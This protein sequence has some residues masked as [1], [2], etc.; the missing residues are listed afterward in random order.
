MNPF[1]YKPPAWVNTPVPH[2]PKSALGRA[3]D[4]ALSYYALGAQTGVHAM[5]EWCGVMGEH[6]KMLRYAYEVKGVE[7]DQVDQH[8][9]TKVEV[10]AFM[11][12]YFCE[13]LGCQLKPFIRGNREVWQREINKWFEGGTPDGG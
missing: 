10:P 11:V 13:K 3:D 2:E 9:G 6:V 5:I 1:A 12:E 4:L 8:S 7:P